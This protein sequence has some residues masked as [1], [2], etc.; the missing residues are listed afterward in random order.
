MYATVPLGELAAMKW[1]ASF[2]PNVHFYTKRPEGQ[3]GLDGLMTLDGTYS[4]NDDYSLTASVYYRP[5]WYNTGQ[6]FRLG[7]LD[8]NGNRQDP[9]FSSQQGLVELGYAYL[10]FSAAVTENLN[11]DLYAEHRRDLSATNPFILFNEDETSYGL[12]LSTSL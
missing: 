7:G 8:V 2:V 12:V 10:Y 11:I 1:S 9:T 5:L 4:F 3:N 6:R